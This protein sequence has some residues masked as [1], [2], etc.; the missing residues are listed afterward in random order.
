MWLFEVD[1]K[2]AKLGDCTPRAAHDRLMEKLKSAGH[3]GKMAMFIEPGLV[4]QSETEG[5]ATHVVYQDRGRA[6]ADKA[7]AF[8]HRLV[9]GGATDVRRYDET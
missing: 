1:W 5:P 8:V 9:T 6:E 3:G 2:T 4:G 7:T